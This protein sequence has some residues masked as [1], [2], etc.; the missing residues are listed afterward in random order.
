MFR[1]DFLKGST[2]AAALF[3]LPI[4][5]VLSEFP[6]LKVGILRQIFH[7]S[8]Y[9]SVQGFESVQEYSS[10]KQAYQELRN[11]QID[12]LISSPT[13]LSHLKPELLFMS[14]ETISNCYSQLG[15][16]SESVA[17]LSPLKIRIS[18]LSF[19]DLSQWKSLTHAPS[20]MASGFDAVSFEHMGFSL[21]REQKMHKLT[22]Q[23]AEM[24][25][26]QLNLTNAYAPALFLNAL[27]L[28]QK[29]EI[30][31]SQ[32]P[33]RN[34]VMVDDLSN[35]ASV[36]ELVY[37][38]NSRSGRLEALQASLKSYL[39]HDEALQQKSL[40]AILQLPN[41]TFAEKLPVQLR[42]SYTRYNSFYTDTLKADSTTSEH[43]VS[44]LKSLI[45]VA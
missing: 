4:T 40:Q 7:L 9:D 14:P 29:I 8:G 27:S 1:R 16:K 34:L 42:E 36:V 28:N 45:G 22:M 39:Q 15:L 38:N 20:V 25:K 10:F 41:F 17:A 43:M 44:N 24:S 19:Q 21:R 35:S 5:H 2:S 26:N 18:N 3:A 12:V 13:L 37:R 11:G 30:L 6:N 32:P 31:P 23:L 33:F